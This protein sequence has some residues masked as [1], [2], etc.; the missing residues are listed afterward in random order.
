MTVDRCLG[1]M[2]VVF[3]SAAM[4]GSVV[5]AFL[6]GARAGVS[7]LFVAGYLCW[8]A[9]DYRRCKAGRY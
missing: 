6:E 8:L 7:S 2:A 9:V 3:I 1:A 4:A 5:L